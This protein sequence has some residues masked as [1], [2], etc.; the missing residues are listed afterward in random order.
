[1]TKRLD[2]GDDGLRDRLVLEETGQPIETIAYVSAKVL[3][4]G[5]D[6]LAFKRLAVTE[7]YVKGVLNIVLDYR[8][9]SVGNATDT[10]K[11]TILKISKCAPADRI[12][13]LHLSDE[14]VTSHWKDALM[15]V[16]DVEPVEIPKIVCAAWERLN[17]RS[18]LL[19]V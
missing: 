6:R 3:E 16:S 4:G 15:L 9:R 12:N 18:G 14:S 19:P 7:G 11:T 1:M 5:E 2:D 17:C 8:D 13:Q 10:N